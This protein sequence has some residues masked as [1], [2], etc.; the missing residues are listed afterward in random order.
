[1][2][3]LSLI[4]LALAT[5]YWAYAISRTHGPY[6]VFLWLQGSKE[7]PRFGGLTRC[8]VCLSVWLAVG[9]WFLL[10]TPLYPVVT[11]SAVAGLATMAGF[12]TGTW[13]QPPN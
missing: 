4:T 3:G 13:L 1:M 8:P 11:I 6:N 9:F 10:Q 12:Y 7:R 5:G 2:D